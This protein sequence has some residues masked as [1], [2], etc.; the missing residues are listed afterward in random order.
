MHAK[1]WCGPLAEIAFAL[2][3]P[4]TAQCAEDIFPSYLGNKWPLILMGIGFAATAAGGAVR[5]SG[6]HSPRRPAAE[7]RLQ[8]A[9]GAD[10]RVRP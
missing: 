7:D 3:R 4:P 8:P 10:P 6:Q 2:A 5:T 1:V 9:D